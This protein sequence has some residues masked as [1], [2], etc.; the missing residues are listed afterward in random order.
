MPKLIDTTPGPMLAGERDAAEQVVGHRVG[1]LDQHDA[2]E[3]RDRVRPLHVELDLGA[4][5]AL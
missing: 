4:Q 2:R 1:H 5:P 3:R